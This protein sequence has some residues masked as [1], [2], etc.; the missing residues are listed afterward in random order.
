MTASTSPAVDARR[1]VIAL[2]SAADPAELARGVALIGCVEGAVLLRQPETGLVMLRGRIG[3]D[4]QPFN[5]GEA[6]VSRCVV[7]LPTGEIGHGIRLGRDRLAAR[8]AAILDAYWQSPGLRVRL[9]EQFLKPLRARIAADRRQA[10][11]E[12]AATRVD[13]FTLARE[14]T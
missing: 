14:A 2:L 13:F 10:S 6:T 4:G 8:N 5:V 3:G 9:E 12:A 7:R 11:R 1:E